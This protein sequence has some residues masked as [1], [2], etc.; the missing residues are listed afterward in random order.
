MKY[1][2][3]YGE[4]RVLAK[5][6]E[7]GVEA[8]PALKTNQEHYDITA[9]LPDLRVRRIQVKATKLANASTNNAIAGV[10]KDY[11]YLVVVI[12]EDGESTAVQEN[13]GTPIENVVATEYRARFFVLKKEEVLV[14]KGQSKLLGV[15]RLKAGV[16]VVKESLARHEDAWRKIS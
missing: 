1:I 8:Y 4:Y 3:K 13:S 16:S 10:D 15:S 5:L 11:D 7:M 12:V 2:G 14:L 9:I 6:L